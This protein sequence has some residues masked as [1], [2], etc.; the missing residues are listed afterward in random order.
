[1]RLI[2]KIGEGTT[3]TIRLPL[4]CER[5]R[6]RRHSSTPFEQAPPLAEADERIK[7]SA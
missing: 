4:D 3:V 5:A 2:S 6:P 7:I 1:M